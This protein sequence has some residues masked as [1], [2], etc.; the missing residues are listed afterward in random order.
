MLVR[1]NTDARILDGE[2]NAAGIPGAK[3]AL[4][5]E[6]AHVPMTEAPEAF[7]KVLLPFLR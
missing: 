6:T 5:A 3:L 7:L 1:R 2:G 4:I